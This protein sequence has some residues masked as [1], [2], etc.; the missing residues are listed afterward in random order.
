LDSKDSPR[1]QKRIARLGYASLPLPDLPLDH[2]DN[3][4]DYAKAM[5]KAGLRPT[6]FASSKSPHRWL[7]VYASHEPLF[8]YLGL[9]PSTGVT[10]SIAVERNVRLA[11]RLIG[12]TF[13]LVG[14]AIREPDQ[15]R[16]LIEASADA[17]VVG[18][19]VLRRV[20]RE[21][22]VDAKRFACTMW[23]AVHKR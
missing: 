12:D 6:F 7:V 10:L 9:Q 1:Q 20:L 23:N 14:F 15:A 21:G 5:R 18:S 22:L 16:R 8:I 13:L 4:S 11:R 17:V 3:L 19:E 2:P